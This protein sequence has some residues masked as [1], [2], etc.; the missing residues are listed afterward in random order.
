VTFVAWRPLWDAV[1]EEQP[2][3]FTDSVVGVKQTN[4]RRCVNGSRSL[5]KKNRDR[6]KALRRITRR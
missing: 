6:T 3:Y 1:Q 2:F 5:T 4:W